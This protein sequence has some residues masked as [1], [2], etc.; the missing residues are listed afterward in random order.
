[1]LEV[2][3]GSLELAKDYIEK[4][5]IDCVVSITQQNHYKPFQARWVKMGG[6]MWKEI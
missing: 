5:I 2:L 6:Q 3:N 4:K 1:M